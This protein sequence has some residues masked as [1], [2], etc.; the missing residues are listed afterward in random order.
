MRSWIGYGIDGRC[1]A[2]SPDS[3]GRSHLDCQGTGDWQNLANRRI[4]IVVLSSTSWPRIQKV[5]SSIVGAI[6]HTLH[7]MPTVLRIGSYR[8]F[9]YANENG[10]PHHIHVQRERMLAKFW[11]KPVSLAS[12]SGFPAQE[13]SKLM[14]MVEANQ[15]LF[16]EAWNG[17]FSS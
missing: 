5:V 12:S 4:A 3:K 1:V 9:F 15:Q 10:E 17:F 2:S 16:V 14:G 7:A 8:F 6:R 13:L 11:L